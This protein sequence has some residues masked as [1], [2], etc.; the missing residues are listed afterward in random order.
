MR[1]GDVTLTLGAGPALFDERFGLAAA[2]PA[3]LG[4]LPAF[5]RHALEPASC[6]GE[7][8]LQACAV[9]AGAA[10]AALVCVSGRERTWI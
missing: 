4:G 3:A 1:G 10:R 9:E 8:C 5:P 2:R 7:H 6:G